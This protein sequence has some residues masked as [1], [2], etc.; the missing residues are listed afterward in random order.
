MSWVSSGNLVAANAISVAIHER[1]QSYKKKQFVFIPSFKIW[2]FS[3]K[4][5]SKAHTPVF[6][7][8]SWFLQLCSQ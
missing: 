8:W 3:P 5:L 2:Y 4:G 7:N 1:S 6:K